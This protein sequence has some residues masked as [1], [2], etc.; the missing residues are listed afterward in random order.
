MSDPRMW[1]R[2]R[3]G[4]PTREYSGLP[5]NTSQS[6][7]LTDTACTLTSTSWSL[8]TG[9]STSASRS[10]PGGPYRVYTTAFMGWLPPATAHCRLRPTAPG[11][12]TSMRQGGPGR[13]AAAGTATQYRRRLPRLDALFE[14]QPPA[15][16]SA[17]I[18]L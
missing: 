14:W 8:G 16:T 3:N 10:T 9:V 18:A 15:R 13:G 17:Q 11:P 6:E 1:C 2:G 7:A 5:R 12:A 4:P